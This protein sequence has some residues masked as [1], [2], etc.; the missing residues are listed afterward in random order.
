MAK[1]KP[2]HPKKPFY[3]RVPADLWEHLE[4]A[5]AKYE[6]RQPITRQAFYNACLERGLPIIE[7]EIK[8]L[9]KLI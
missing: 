6:E 9:P 4:E 5:F 7:A 1:P 2:K 8:N 3:T